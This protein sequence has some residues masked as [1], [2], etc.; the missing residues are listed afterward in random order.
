[1]KIARILPVTNHQ[2][3]DHAH[4][5]APP[6][7]IYAGG[8][9]LGFFLH[10]AW[11]F[12]FLP[13][14]VARWIGLAFVALFFVLAFPAVLLMR[15]AGTSLRPDEPTKVLITAGP[16]RYTRNPIYL[17]FASLYI[18]T[19]LVLNALWP[20]VLLP[21]VLVVMDRA[22]IAREEAYLERKFGETY[23]QYKARVRRWL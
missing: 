15:G 13:D 16:F 22:V 3:H 9:L 20:L 5:I 4:V 11:P 1:L 14:D 7:L 19:S 17:S 10:R 6:P 8:L 2:P 18:G 21:I 12:A 23:R